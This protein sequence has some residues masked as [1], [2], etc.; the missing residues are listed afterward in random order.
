MLN[1]KIPKQK[2]KIK[3]EAIIPR[4]RRQVSLFFEIK[5][6]N[7]NKAKEIAPNKIIKYKS[8][9]KKERSSTPNKNPKQIV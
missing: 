8:I 6:K 9:N 5:V 3:I 1:L 2:V 4:L 7:K